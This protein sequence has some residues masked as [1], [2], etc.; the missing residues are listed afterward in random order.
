MAKQPGGKL[1]RS[2]SL[3]RNPVQNSAEKQ[4]WREAGDRT[5]GAAQPVDNQPAACNYFF[6][7]VGFLLNLTLAT[8]LRFNLRTYGIYQ[9]IVKLL[10]CGHRRC[11]W[12]NE[13]GRRLR[14]CAC[15]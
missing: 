5:W 11:K 13:R 15:H 3:L 6:V 9:P 7:M 14:P 1:L 8:K 10:S 2:R 12:P 4:Q